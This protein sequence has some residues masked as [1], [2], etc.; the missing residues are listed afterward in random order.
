M[1]EFKT[2]DALDR[3]IESIIK[4]H[5]KHYYSDWKHH[6]RPKYMG[7]KGSTDKTDKDLILIV[8][9]CGTE[10]FTRKKAETEGTE[11]NLVLNYYKEQER[12]G[13][14][15]YAINLEKLTIKETV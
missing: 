8:R 11:A 14:K 13:T 15:F 3:K 4:A 6:D 7:F 2:I 5:V 9:E 12:L 1:A 10:L